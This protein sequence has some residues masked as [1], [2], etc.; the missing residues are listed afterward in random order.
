MELSH[1]HSPSDFSL[2]FLLRSRTPVMA[3]DGSVWE[4]RGSPV[5]QNRYNSL[6]SMPLVAEW[7][8]STQ[9]TCCWQSHGTGVATHLPPKPYCRFSG[10]SCHQQDSPSS[11]A[12]PEGKSALGCLHPGGT[13]KHCRQLCVM[14]MGRDVAP[15]PWAV[16]EHPVTQHKDHRAKSCLTWAGHENGLSRANVNLMSSCL[17]RSQ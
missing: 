5:A 10:H 14:E 12:R 1:L 2:G 6:Q 3:L 13:S 9:L 8:D 7:W 15:T 4:Y 11:F 16:P 17:S